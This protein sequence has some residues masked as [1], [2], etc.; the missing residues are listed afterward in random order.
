MSGE[1][2]AEKPPRPAPHRTLRRTLLVAAAA[3]LLLEVTGYAA[4]KL[5]LPPKWSKDEQTG[6]MT[7]GFSGWIDYADRVQGRGARLGFLTVNRLGYR[8]RMLE[9]RNAPNELRVGCWGSSTT[10]GWGASNDDHTYPARLEEILQA[11]WPGRKVAVLNAGIPGQNSRSE[12]RLLKEDLPRLDLDAVVLWSGWPD[13][14]HYLRRP[15]AEKKRRGLL[16]WLRHKSSAVRLAVW[17]LNI[18]A[19]KIKPPDEKELAARPGLS[20]F[21]EPVLRD[22]EKRLRAMIA[23]CRRQ[24]VRPIVIGLGGPLCLE[25]LTPEARRLAAYQ[26]YALRDANLQN[27]RVALDRFNEVLRRVTRDTGT[28]LVGYERLPREPRLFLDV[29]H[30]TDEGYRRLAQVVAEAAFTGK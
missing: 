14:T 11:R 21:N 5:L 28:K 4:R 19:P 29:A 27:M 2:D 9:K 12:L 15:G 25:P 16:G 17:L 1:A 13:W 26:L 20:K 8:G 22:F 23:L 24:G 7:A 3:L 10:F 18:T 30:M 6:R